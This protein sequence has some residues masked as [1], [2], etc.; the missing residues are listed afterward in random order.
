MN[1]HTYFGADGFNC[2]AYG[3]YAYGECA[4]QGTD[5]G[6]SYTGEMII[7]PLALGAAILIASTILLVRKIRRNKKSSTNSK[8]K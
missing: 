1:T 7:L 3:Q 2:D 5:T 8:S 4:V 6:L